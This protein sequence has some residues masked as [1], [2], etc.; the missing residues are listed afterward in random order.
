MEKS[1]LAGVQY[2]QRGHFILVILISSL[3]IFSCNFRV[4]FHK[5]IAH[6]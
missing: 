5:G 6:L 3:L 1:L 2:M 4:L